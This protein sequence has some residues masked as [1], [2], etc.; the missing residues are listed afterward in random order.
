MIAEKYEMTIRKRIRVRSLI[1]WLL[2]P[3]RQHI[4]SSGFEEGSAGSESCAEEKN[5]SYGE[6]S[7][8]S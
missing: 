4:P 5:G 8:I 6:G 3:I 2:A 7:M 1:P